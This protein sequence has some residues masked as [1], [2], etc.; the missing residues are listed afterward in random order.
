ME[1][2][3]LPAASAVPPFRS[4]HDEIQ[5]VRG[6]QLEPAP[7]ATPRLVRSVE[8][9]HHHA[10][11][12]ACDGVGEELLASAVLAA[13]ILG[14][15][16]CSGTRASSISRRSRAGR[17]RRSSPSTMEHVE[18]E[19]GERSLRGRLAIRPA[20][21]AAH[22]HLEPVGRAVGFQR[23][24]L[25]VEHDR[26]DRKGESHLD[27]LRHAIGDVGEAP[28]ERAHVPSEPVH[29]QA[30]AVEL[31]LDGRGSK[32]L[33]GTLEVVGRLREHRLHGTQDLQLE[34]GARARH[35]RARQRQPHRR[36]PSSIA[37]RRTAAGAIPAAFATA[38]I[39]TPSSA[40]CRSSPSEK[41]REK[42]LFPLR[43]APEEAVELSPADRLGPLADGGCDAR[44]GAV[45]LQELE[46]R[47]RLGRSWEDS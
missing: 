40:P 32:S 13:A 3:E 43:R 33:E 21:E 12:A 8:R 7:T 10:L 20:P 28:R 47:R 46:R 1:V 4:Q 25:T 17:S 29:L 42:A 6:L 23:D 38:S 15:R 24:R 44:H 2:R 5:R 45:H 11:V 18:E 36:R 41:G 35:R 37:A 27:H 31:P 34:A 19:R 30:S 22:R 9:L 14:T 16:F 26:V 39:M